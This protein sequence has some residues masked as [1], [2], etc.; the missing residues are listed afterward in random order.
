MCSSFV[1]EQGYDIRDESKESLVDENAGSYWIFVVGFCFTWGEKVDCGR[2][3]HGIEFLAYELVYWESL[4]P[5]DVDR[6]GTNRGLLKG[7]WEH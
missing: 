3:N 5:K 2:E 4:I 1:K 6:Y 7:L